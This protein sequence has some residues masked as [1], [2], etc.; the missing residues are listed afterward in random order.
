M[1]DFPSI[2]PIFQFIAALIEATMTDTDETL[3]KFPCEYPIKI[4]G[5]STDAFEPAVITIV[6]KHV[7]DL[8][9][10]AVKI[11]PSG[12]GNFV[13]MTVTFEAQSKAQLDSLYQELHDCEH[14]VML[15]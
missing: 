6:R 8:G 14:V 5:R 1:I 15:L 7:T 4:M 11:K 13:S 10:G 9:E 3:F 12:K 2:T